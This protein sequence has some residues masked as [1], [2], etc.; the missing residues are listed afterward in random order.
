MSNHSFDN[1]VSPETY[2]CHGPFDPDVFGGV[3]NPPVY[4][5][6]T[7]IFKN[8]KELSERHQALFEDAEDEVMYYGRFGT[9]HHLCR[10]K[11]SGG[12]GGRLSFVAGSYGSGRLHQRIIGSGKK[13]RSYFGQQQRVRSDAWVRE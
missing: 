2:L 13:R 1:Q 11:G 8:C 7:V 6:S 9:P 10:A 5:A 12:A 4:H 3:V